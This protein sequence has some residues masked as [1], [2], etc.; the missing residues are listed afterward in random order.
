MEYTQFLS[1]IGEGR[2]ERRFKGIYFFSFK[3]SLQIISPFFLLQYPII[4]IWNDI[5]ININKYYLRISLVK[6][7]SDFFLQSLTPFVTYIS[8]ILNNSYHF[9][10]NL[11]PY[12]SLIFCLKC[13]ISSNFFKILHANS[14]SDYNVPLFFPVFNILRYKNININEALMNINFYYL[15]NLIFI[16]K[17]CIK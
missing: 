5:L 3:K 2:G 16:K 7:N 1:E 9:F 11:L 13:Y 10:L 4:R 12:F 15:F 17:I 14:L 6:T 8:P